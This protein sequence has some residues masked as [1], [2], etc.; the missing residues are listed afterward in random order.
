MRIVALVY[1][2][3]H[4]EKETLPGDPGLTASGLEQAVRVARW[5]HGR[6]VRSLF[7]SPQR[8]AWQT[9]EIIASALGLTVTPDPRLRERMNWE[10]TGILEDFLVNWQRSV[11]DRDFVPPGGESS[12]Q[13]GERM[14]GFLL[15][16]SAEQG[17]V[18]A[19]THGGATT[20]LLRTLV[21][22][23]QLPPGLLS[24]GLSPCATTTLNGLAVA[25]IASVAHLD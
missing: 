13:V 11:L 25:K 12:R 9:A 8:R 10:G 1:L 15:G 19:V 4:A 20:D 3:Q 21:G 14:R 7:S 23:D 2:V 24:E 6:D 18:A 17:S 5:L 22:D 16:Q